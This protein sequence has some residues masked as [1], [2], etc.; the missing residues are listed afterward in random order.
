MSRLED[1]RERLE[2]REAVIGVVGL[3]YVGL[4]LA[5]EFAKNGYPVLGFDVDPKKVEALSEGRSYIEDVDPDTVARVVAEGK[6]AASG[7]FGEPTSR[8]FGFI[9]EWPTFHITG[10]PPASVITSAVAREAR[11]S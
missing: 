11:I 1:L 9:K 2:R 8:I 6:L 4:P 5:L 10:V 7:D 3:G